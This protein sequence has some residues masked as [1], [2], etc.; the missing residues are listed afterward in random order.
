MPH[1]THSKR[2][3]PPGPTFVAVVA[4]AAAF[5]GGSLRL[6]CLR[7]TGAGG[8]G[9]GVETAGTCNISRADHFKLLPGT[10]KPEEEDE[11]Y[12][13]DNEEDDEEAED[14]ELVG[15]P[16]PLFDVVVFSLAPICSLFMS[17]YTTEGLEGFA[18][19]NSKPPASQCTLRR[20]A[21]C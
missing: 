19:R 5:D 12:E 16:P 7:A 17:S 21:L 20:T 14:E 8:G 3:F 1:S 4:A 15:F 2:G 9:G 11:G 13:E 10:E 6:R 18:Y